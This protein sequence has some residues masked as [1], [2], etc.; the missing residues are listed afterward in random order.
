MEAIEKLSG[1]VGVATRPARRF[2]LNLSAEAFEDMEFLSNLG[3]PRS[4]SEV[5][6]LA[7]SLLKTVYP[8]IVRGEELY[9]V[10][11]KN[12]TERQIILPK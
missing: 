3:S 2:S 1:K 10:D 9:L 5:F 6:R 4:M 7:L 11:P 12:N 8:A